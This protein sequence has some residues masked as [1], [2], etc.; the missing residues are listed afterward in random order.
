[1]HVIT[2]RLEVTATTRAFHEYRFVSSAE[3]VT[4]KLV[5]MI[6]AQRVGAQ[7]P[8]HSFYEVSIGRFDDG[9]KVIRHQTIGMHLKTG[10]LASFSQRFQKILPIDI[11][12]EDILSSVARGSSHDKSH[13]GNC[14]LGLR[15]ISR[16]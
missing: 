11:I 8:A 13:P 16:E 15:G 5:P 4:E 10:L 12:Q 3:D 9:M 6:Q 1:M 2:C 7:Q 14:T